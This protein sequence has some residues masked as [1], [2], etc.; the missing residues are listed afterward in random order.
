MLPSQRRIN[1]IDSSAAPQLSF[2]KKAYHKNK[3]K[4]GAGNSSTSAWTES[5]PGLC[6]ANEMNNLPP[7]ER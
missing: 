1:D 4:L 5:I 6:N 3:I 7:D 2:I